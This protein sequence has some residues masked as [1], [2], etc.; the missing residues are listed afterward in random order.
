MDLE[1]L[2]K[3][4]NLQPSTLKHGLFVVLMIT[5]ILV[6]HLLPDLNNSLASRLT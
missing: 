6:V 1:T 2:Y 3:K 4:F 5:L